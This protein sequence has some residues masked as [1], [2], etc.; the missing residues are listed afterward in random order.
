M[1]TAAWVDLMIDPHLFQV[2]GTNRGR[3]RRISFLLA[4]V[5]GGFL[6]ATL[7]RFAGSD[8]AL[9]VSAVGK[10]VVG[11]AYLFVPAEKHDDAIKT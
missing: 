10:M 11:M 9:M 1:A 4:L 3:N 5:A 2:R 8:H 6:G 7:Y